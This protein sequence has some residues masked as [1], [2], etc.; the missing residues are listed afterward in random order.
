MKALT[1]KTVQNAKARDRRIEIPDGGCRGLYLVVQPTSAKSWA[2]RYRL[3]GKPHKLTLGSALFLDRADVEPDQ[4]VIDGPLSLAAAR[5]LATEA[6]HQVKLGRHPGHAKKA[7]RAAA[8]QAAADTFEAIAAAY[9]S[10]EGG[11]LRSADWSRAVLARLVFPTIGLR[12]I[13]DIRRS[14]IVR[15]LDKIEEGSGAVMADRTLAIV[16]RIM[17]WH[18]SRSDD[19]R[20]PIVRGMARTKP[21]E[22]ARERVLTDEE[23]RTLW[24]GACQT[25]GPFGRF[26][27]FL[28]LTG[29]RRNEAAHL[30]WSE[31]SGV[32]WTLPASRNKTKV[33]LVRPL[34][35]AAQD[36]LSR[37]E[38]VK[39]CDFVFATD[40]RSPISGFS[41][42]KRISM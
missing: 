22:R 33:D 12:A 19:F 40:G 26:V 24:S 7:R 35:Q 30:K 6:M 20:S 14:E 16:R 39:D 9:M 13:A 2:V 18:A 41:R 28:L 5:K 3:G 1:A 31:L 10:R 38:R 17:N 23:L 27:Q 11:R 32:D 29:A 25:E 4:V 34:S 21:K 37:V 8:A 36:V 42:F 15:L